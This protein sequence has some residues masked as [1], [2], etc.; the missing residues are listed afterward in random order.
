MIEITSHRQGA[1]LNH[2]HGIE[3]ESSLK[4]RVE[5]ISESGRPVKVNGI[6][7][8]MDGR[9]FRADVELK[10][11]FNK[12]TANNGISFMFKNTPC[13]TIK[14]IAVC[15]YYK[16]GRMCFNNLSYQSFFSPKYL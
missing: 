7:A 9:I 4:I 6:P 13:R 1:I 8:E 14:S 3:T 2:N 10:E 5:G 11:K 16:I 12:I 15:L